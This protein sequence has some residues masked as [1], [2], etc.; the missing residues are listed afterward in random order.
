M[1]AKKRMILQTTKQN[2]KGPFT[3]RIATRKKTTIYRQT[4]KDKTRTT[5]EIDKTDTTCQESTT[6]KINSLK[7]PEKSRSENP[8]AKGGAMHKKK[9]NNGTHNLKTN[10]MRWYVQAS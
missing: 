1:R 8:T 6:P 9:K 3:T 7:N 2:E 4:L 10:C 5:C